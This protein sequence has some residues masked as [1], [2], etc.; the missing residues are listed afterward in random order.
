[1]VFATQQCLSVV[2]LIPPGVKVLILSW[3]SPDWIRSMTVLI[4]GCFNS[5]VHADNES[6]VTHEALEVFSTSSDKPATMLPAI[7]DR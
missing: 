3:D 5:F 4:V 1:M 2:M 6:P 7:E